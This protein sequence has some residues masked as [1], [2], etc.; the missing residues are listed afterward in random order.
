MGANTSVNRNNLYY[1]DHVVSF[2]KIV[3]KNIQNMSQSHYSYKAWSGRKLSILV[4]TQLFE[5]PID[6]VVDVDVDFDE[7][8]GLYSKENFRLRI[9]SPWPAD[10][11]VTP[12]QE[13][14]R[15]FMTRVHINVYPSSNQC[16]VAVLYNVAS[17][18]PSVATAKEKQALSGLVS[19]TLCLGIRMLYDA[20]ALTMSG[21]VKI[22]A[23]GMLRRDPVS[24]SHIPHETEEQ[25][26]HALHAYL[27]LN[28]SKLTEE[29]QLQKIQTIAK[30]DVVV[31]IYEGLGF[32]K[33]KG[34]HDPTNV[35]MESIVFNILSR[36][37]QKYL[38]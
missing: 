8:R 15:D 16:H 35:A 38:T 25:R 5:Y 33:I 2:V 37:S 22:N 27:I 11:P 28:P 31:K 30:T 18:Y 13:I 6:T 3:S 19:E 24:I 7:A 32:E 20:K 23:V 29:E 17:A 1:I 26:L 12:L 34:L 4:G 9:E 36:C 10:Y 21:Y 14:H